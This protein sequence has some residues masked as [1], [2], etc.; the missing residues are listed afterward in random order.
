MLKRT[1]VKW[2]SK[3]FI[4]KNILFLNCE[5]RSRRPAEADYEKLFIDLAFSKP[6]KS[7]GK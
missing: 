7:V 3:L 6:F 2:N 1:A 5:N 4:S